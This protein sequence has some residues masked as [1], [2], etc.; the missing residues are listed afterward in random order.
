MTPVVALTVS[1][2]FERFEPG[3]LTAM[4]VAL[5]VL[6]NRWMLSRPSVAVARAAE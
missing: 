5:A 3:L 6:G 4:G 1:T 2:L